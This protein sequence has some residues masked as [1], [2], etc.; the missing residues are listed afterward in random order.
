[1]L[2]F[3]GRFVAACR[4]SSCRWPNWVSRHLQRV[5]RPVF[6]KGAEN[7]EVFGVHDLGFE[8][9]L[10]CLNRWIPTS[11]VFLSRSPTGSL[12][13]RRGEPG[14]H[15]AAYDAIGFLGSLPVSI[16]AP[17]LTQRSILAIAAAESAALA[18]AACA[19]RSR[20]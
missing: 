18:L 8:A 14:R 13:T 16:V 2:T 9:A 19:A 6:R 20:P 5:V 10:A 11:S 3:S 12:A 7:H 17:S 15:S 1:M 4:E